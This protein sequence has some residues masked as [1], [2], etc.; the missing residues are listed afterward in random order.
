M[1]REARD[2]YKQLKVHYETMMLW[3][4]M[5]HSVAHPGFADGLLAS[6]GKLETHL[7]DLTLLNDLL[8]RLSRLS[9]LIYT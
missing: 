8:R 9:Q 1:S 5:Y 7:T 3:V 4:A 6:S 2:C